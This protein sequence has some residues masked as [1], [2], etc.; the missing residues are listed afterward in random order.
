MKRL[1]SLLGDFTGYNGTD[2]LA[3]H[4]VT[5]QRK[6]GL[7][8][9]QVALRDHFNGTAEDAYMRQTPA[10]ILEGAP[11]EPPR[12]V[13]M[14]T[15]GYAHSE[16]ALGAG[17]LLAVCCRCLLAAPLPPAR[18]PPAPPAPPHLA[19]LQ[20]RRCGRRPAAC[21]PRC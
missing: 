17:N 10:P 1:L 9:L 18:R 4:F 11:G 12:P 6:L 7:R 19:A 14:L 3:P 21:R 5:P 16:P 8:D 20:S 13:A 15:T 2:G